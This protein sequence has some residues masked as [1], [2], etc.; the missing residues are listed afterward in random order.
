MRS[1]DDLVDSDPDKFFKLMSHSIKDY[2][3]SGDITGEIMT[4]II[5]DKLTEIYSARLNNQENIEVFH[6]VIN[7]FETTPELTN[8]IKRSLETYIKQDR[9]GGSHK[10]IYE[11][12]LSAGL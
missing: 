7:L 12:V 6:R 2:F 4:E 10:K 3:T 11:L 1:I 5:K 8:S 9:I